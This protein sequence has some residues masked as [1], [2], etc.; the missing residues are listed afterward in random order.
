MALAIIISCISTL[1]LFSIINP[2]NIELFT[3]HKYQILLTCL[4]L[5][6]ILGLID[7][8]FTLSPWP[9][10]AIQIAIASCLWSVGISIDFL[11]LNW[12]QQSIFNIQLPE[13]ISYAITIFWLVGFT[14]ALNW[15]DGLDGLAGGLSFICLLGNL[16]ISNLVGNSNL[17]YLNLVLIGS[18]IAFLKFNKHPSSIMM[19]DGG[20]YFLGFSL[21]SISILNY[22]LNLTYPFFITIL[23][24]AIPLIDMFFVI[25][26]PM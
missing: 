21:S 6:Y 13:I 26:K 18:I 8:L 19:G 22:S 12:M 25:L 17:I 3:D 9:R 16:V 4:S 20:S 5:S 14:N 24:F 2:D 10:L 1:F 7:D 15:I 11:N 23:L